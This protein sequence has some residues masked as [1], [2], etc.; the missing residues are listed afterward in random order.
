MI[1]TSFC[2]DFLLSLVIKRL[3]SLRLQYWYAGTLPSQCQCHP[4]PQ[5]TVVH[6]NLALYK[7]HYLL[8]GTYLLTLIWLGRYR[9]LGIAHF[10]ILCFMDVV[11]IFANLRIE[12]YSDL[13]LIIIQYYYCTRKRISN[14]ERF[15]ILAYVVNTRWVIGRLSINVMYNSIQI[16]SPS[17]W[18][19]Y[20]TRWGRVRANRFRWELLYYDQELETWN[21][22]GTL[23]G[24]LKNIESSNI[25]IS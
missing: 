14:S 11:F 6:L 13:F 9:I 20:E 8:T 21:T 2:R 25:E 7:F 15:F 3:T 10:Y 24:T 5:I 23:K 1:F 12:Y 16:H 18:A 19:R 17:T 22:T 4:A